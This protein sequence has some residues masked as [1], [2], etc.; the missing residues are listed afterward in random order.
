MTVLP[1]PSLKDIETGA[2]QAALDAAGGNLSAAARRLGI[3][4]T[5]LYRKLKGRGAPAA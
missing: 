3:A 5:T 2:V 1:A 4:R